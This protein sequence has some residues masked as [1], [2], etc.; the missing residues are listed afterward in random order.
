MEDKGVAFLEQ[1]RQG[2]LMEAAKD[3]AHCVIVPAAGSPSEVQTKLREEVGRVL[4][5]HPR[6]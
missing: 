4:A 5:R 2:F 6:P 3:P 1:V